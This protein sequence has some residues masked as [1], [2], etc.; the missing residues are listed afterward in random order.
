[1]VKLY[2][3]MVKLYTTTT[4]T[5]MVTTTTTKMM[6]TTGTSITS[7]CMTTRT[8]EGRGGTD[9]YKCMNGSGL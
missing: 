2:K 9:E 4:T 3:S 1:M 6:M 7:G 5:I 8:Q